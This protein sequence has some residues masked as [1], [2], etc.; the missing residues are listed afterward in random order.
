MTTTLYQFTP[1]TGQNFSFLPTLDGQEYSAIVT[2]S[3]FGQRWILNIFTLQGGFVMQKPL[4][5]SPTNYDINL[6]AG[7]FTST[8]LV[9]RASTNNIEVI[10]A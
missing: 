6:I 5:A 3:L 4:T 2:W 9:Y 8:S 7:Y 10:A 1:T